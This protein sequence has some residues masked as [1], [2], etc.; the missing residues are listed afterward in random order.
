VHEGEV[1]EREL[2]REQLH[3][4]IFDPNEADNLVADPAYA[5]V[6]DEL[7]ARL[8]DWMRRTDDPLLDGPV[9]PP[10]GTEHN[11]PS[12]RSAADPTFVAPRA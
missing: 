10:P 5:D 4:L 12:Q 1:L 8:E 11:D 3:D 2:P 9:A 6:L 7:R